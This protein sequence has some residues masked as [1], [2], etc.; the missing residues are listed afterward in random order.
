MN[1]RSQDNF[2]DVS[3]KG[4]CCRT[5]VAVN[6]ARQELDREQ[7]SVHGPQPSFPGFG[8]FALFVEVPDME[9][10]AAQ[11]CFEVGKLKD[12]GPHGSG[13]AMVR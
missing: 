5:I 4:Q 8:D 1:T 10:S 6:A 9:I 13:T 12:P 11:Q 3:L 2:P 7:F